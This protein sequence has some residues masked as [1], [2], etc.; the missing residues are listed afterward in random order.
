MNRVDLHKPGEISYTE[1]YSEFKKHLEGER[2]VGCIVGF[3]GIVRGESR[4]KEVL[5]LSYEAYREMAL[6]ELSR[7]VDYIG[8]M[9]GVVEVWI[10][11]VV[12]LT[13]PG[14]E[15]FYVLVAADHRKNAFKAF[16]PYPIRGGAA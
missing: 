16:L 10:H 1:L 5:K 15:T 9:E 12:G 3:V 7:L 13:Y 8:R 2:R 4:G 14:D 11:H 6:K